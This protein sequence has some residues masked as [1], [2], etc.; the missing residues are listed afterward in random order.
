MSGSGD[1][2][3]HE[4]EVA[5]ELQLLERQAQARRARVARALRLGSLVVSASFVFLLRTDLRYALRPASPV[6]LGG[7][8][9]FQF[10]REA[11][12][13][14]ATVSGLPGELS[15]AADHGGR[16]LRMF[17]LLTTN[18]VVVQDLAEVGP[19]AQPARNQPYVATGR[20]VRDDD[21]SE[22]RVVFRVL[23][24]R[25][26]VS[27]Q[28]EH[29]YALLEGEAPRKDWALPLELLG[30]LAFVAVNFRAA[31]KMQHP[32]PLGDWDGASDG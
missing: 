13:T 10:E 2:A 21:A 15:P 14:Y 11:S 1:P 16:H 3:G 31:Y 4:A 22:F 8:M 23:E 6:A 29:L 19:E 12:Q 27:R 24:D 17:G 32:L 18:I 28:D 5:A 9:E 30:I 20:L 26:I 7:P 25:G